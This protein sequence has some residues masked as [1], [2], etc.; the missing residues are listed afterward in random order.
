MMS[1][2]V[3][4]RFRR[5]VCAIAI[6]LP[7]SACGQPARPSVFQTT[8]EEAGQATPEITTEQLRAILATNSE[9]VFDVRFARIRHRPHP[10]HDQLFEKEV[11]RIIEL[12]PD[13]RRR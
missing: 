10:W 4:L 1:V 8:L 11:E 2:H 13:H 3:P 5:L 7:C 12:Y 9:P 6:L